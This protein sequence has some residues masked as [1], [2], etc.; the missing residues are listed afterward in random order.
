MD[1]DAAVL[2]VEFKISLLSPATGAVIAGGRVV[3]AGR[4][5]TFCAGEAVVGETTVATFSATMMAVRRPG[6]AD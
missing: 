6:L 4:T 5:L 3:K 2:T 1:E